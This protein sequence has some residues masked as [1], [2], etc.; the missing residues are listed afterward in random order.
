MRQE[1]LLKVIRTHHVTEKTMRDQANNVYTFLVL[2]SATKHEI[3]GAVELVYGVK[4]DSI[5]TLNYKPETKKNAR[6]HVG[7]T[8]SYKKALVKLSEGSS[9][10]PQ[11]SIIKGA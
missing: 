7:K 2:P 1:K 6:G 5:R 4:V 9:I 11:A 3:A 10:D 8:S